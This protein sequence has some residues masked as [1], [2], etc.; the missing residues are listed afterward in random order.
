MNAVNMLYALFL[1]LGHLSNTWPVIT[2]V[3]KGGG[4]WAK[5]RIFPLV[6][7]MF[8]ATLRF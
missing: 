8:Q 3:M 5:E 4:F 1:G 6:H 2:L 7:L